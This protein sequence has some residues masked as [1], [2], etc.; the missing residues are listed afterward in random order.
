MPRSMLQGLRVTL[1][2]VLAGKRQQG[3]VASTFDGS[4]HLALVLGTGASLTTRADL[5]I[6]RD[7]AFDKI[8]LF[9][10]NA[11]FFIRAELAELRARVLA[12]LRS[13]AGSSF[14]SHLFLQ[15]NP[16]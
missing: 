2:P 5:A 10:V 8:Y 11:Q 12:A 15:L 13:A 4:C 9:I 16:S 3:D 6:V 7:I 1:F 14:I